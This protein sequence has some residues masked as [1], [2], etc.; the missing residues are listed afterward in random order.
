[1][2]TAAPQALHA[3]GPEFFAYFLRDKIISSC[4]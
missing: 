3:L 4:A 1:M 2:F